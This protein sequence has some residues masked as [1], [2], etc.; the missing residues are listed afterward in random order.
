MTSVLWFFSLL[1]GIT[2]ATARLT[3]NVRPLTAAPTPGSQGRASVTVLT[4]WLVR[5]KVASYQ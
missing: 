5:R 3:E 1:A 2:A 4:F